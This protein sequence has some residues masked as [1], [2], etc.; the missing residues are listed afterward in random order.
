[1]AANPYAAP[2]AAGEAR[3]HETE[4][5][6]RV[7][8]D[9]VTELSSTKHSVQFVAVMGSLACCFF[10]LTAVAAFVG[11]GPSGVGVLYLFLA[12]LYGYPMTLLWS[13]GRHIGHLAST[14]E[15]YDLRD[16]LAAQRK[17]WRFVALASL[18]GLVAM[19]VGVFALSS[20]L[21][22]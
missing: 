5:P 18:L 4:I 7:H 15:H 1:M 19:G 11:R 17:F 12:A 20:A 21:P 13:Y 9:I 22:R 8:V 14:G 10:L 3:A 2:E 6:D 16:A